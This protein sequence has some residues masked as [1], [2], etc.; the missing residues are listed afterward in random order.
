[1][2]MPNVVSVAA[3]AIGSGVRDV[4]W[5]ADHAIGGTVLVPGTALLELAVRAAEETG[6]DR[7][8]ELVL[9]TPLTPGR[10]AVQVQVVVGSAGPSGE[11]PLSVHSRPVDGDHDWITHATGVLRSGEPAPAFDLADWPPPNAESV[12]IEGLYERLA[13]AGHGYGPAFRGLRAV[14]RRA[15]E[16]FAEV[17]L[18][19]AL[20]ADAARYGLHP[21]L[22]DA[23]L[24]AAVAV[25]GDTGPPRL[26]FAW[27]GV[28]LHAVGAAALRVRLV[29]TA[30]DQLAVQVADEAGRPVASV[31]ALTTRAVPAGLLA[32]TGVARRQLLHRLDWVALPPAPTGPDRPWAVL[33]DDLGLG[34]ALFTAGVHL[35]AADQ[36]PAVTLAAVGDAGAEVPDAAA[37][38]AAV[39]RVLGIVRTWLGAVSAADSHLVIVTR[40]AVPV[41]DGAAVDLAYASV[42]GLLRSA[43]TENPG[44]LTV[45]DVDDDSWAALPGV[46]VAAL[47]AGEP[48]VALRDGI[49]YVP[50]VLPDDADALLEP[51]PGAG[52][53]RLEVAGA[54]GTG[55]GDLVLAP[56]PEATAPL[57]AGQVRIAVHAAG[58]NFRDVLITLGMYPQQSLLGGEGA[59]VVLEV[60]PGV[61]D[62]T[63]GDRVMGLFAACG[64]FGPVAVT[65]HR[66]VVPVPLGWSFAEAATVPVAFLTAYQG[67]VE[68]AGLRAGESVLIHAASGG[69]GMAAVQ[70]AEHLGAEVYGTA[71]P[72]KW[73]ALRA[74][75]LPDERIANSRTLDFADSFRQATG[76]QGVDVVLNA[77]AGDFVDASVRL[78]P[79]GGR[80][81]EM[82]KTDLRDPATMPA[83]VTYRAFDLNEAGPDLLGA[84]LR[85]LLDLFANGALRPLPV[86]RWNVRRASAALRHLSQARHVGKVVLT[87]P[88]LDVD[89]AVLVT[90]ATG[91]L[92][93]L[94]ARHLVTAH[95]V[96]RLLLLSRSGGAEDL[97]TELTA[98]GADVTPRACD[99]ADRA[100]LAAVLAEHPVDAVFHVAG[101]LADGL[102]D[103]LTADQVDRV[104]RPKVDGAIN[105]H[106]LTTGLRAFVLFSAASGVLG[107]PGQANYAAAN[108]FLDA[109]AGHRRAQGLTATSLAWGLW[110]PASGMA[111][112]SDADRNRMAR[113][114]ILPL[115][116]EQGLA[117]LD[118]ALSRDEPV[119]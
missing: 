43:Q 99:V 97:V 83:G 46:L 80:F 114:G 15:G 27:T 73:P 95:G 47:A 87:V 39:H 5:L 75:G 33:D 103:T 116:A 49:G 117:L 31:E 48:Q 1:I 78:L 34:A 32:A 112:L 28:Q 110:A 81:L 50:R 4:P 113:G 51:P 44:R 24:H 23:A 72:P 22:L 3:V 53:W 76:G 40:A 58:V 79:R 35:T 101:V 17:Q 29:P 104:L 14:W 107:G 45:L 9:R 26:P 102:A 37:V 42:W 62:L 59:G 115:A 8:E 111:E 84:M 86:T 57:A 64:A 55:V 93:R 77:L 11:R 13:A 90:G 25:P 106:E 98:L 74:A 16:I 66:L 63:P 82:G 30:V 21:A 94:V 88:A 65:D 119:L 71:S 100:A 38:H 52:A 6:G 19:G 10:D 92:G 96:R 12:P 41:R 85:K 67:L 18:P 36:Q 60:G 20:H 2:F 56:A 108:T 61:T 118:A 54:G 7:V 91:A 69:V 105:L 70:I 109:L 68:L 89:G